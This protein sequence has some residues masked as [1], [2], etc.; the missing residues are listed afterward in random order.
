MDK[1]M[2]TIMQK[3]IQR[4]MEALRR[5]RME[6]CYAERAADVPGLVESLLR[7][8]DT[9]AAGGSVTLAEAGVLELLR[10]GRYRFLDRD[11]PGLSPADVRRIQ[12]ESFGADAYLTSANA[13]TEA[14]E[15]YYVDG[16][17]NRAAAVLFGPEQVIVVAG[18]N[19][20]V[21]DL[22][23][24][25]RRVRDTAAPANVQRLS[26]ETYCRESGRCAGADQPAGLA[27]LTR[28]CKADGRICCDY[29]VLGPQRKPGR[30]RVILVGE[31]LGY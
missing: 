7:E 19:K 21:P 14:G 9:V 15:L 13:V 8:G 17:G 20:I 11:V 25:V 1:N 27:G 4:T 26:C 10:S 6:A 3:R 23:S 30:I 5:S 12:L 24:A 31:P 28:G 2:Q 18:V 22:P 29:V 16:N